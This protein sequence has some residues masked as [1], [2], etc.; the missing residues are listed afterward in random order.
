MKC[1]ISLEIFG[2]LYQ[3]QLKFGKQL[4]CDKRC[5]AFPAALLVSTVHVPMQSQLCVC[6]CDPG[7]GEGVCWEDPCQH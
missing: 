4:T 6:V 2:S 3:Y 1:D 5:M 7:P